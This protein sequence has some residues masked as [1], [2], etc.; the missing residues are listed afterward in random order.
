MFTIKQ[1]T[2]A[3]NMFT[4]KQLRNAVNVFTMKQL[5]NAVNM[6]TAFVSCFIVKRENKITTI[7]GVCRH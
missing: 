6:F 7:Y 4:I 5:T 3:V 2:N 1:L